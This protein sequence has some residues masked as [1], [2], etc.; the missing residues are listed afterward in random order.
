ML[1]RKMTVVVF[2]ILLAVL[3]IGVRQAIAMPSAQELVPDKPSKPDAGTPYIL[4][5]ATEIISATID[6]TQPIPSVSNSMSEDFEAT[7]P[8]PGWELDDT[9]TLDGGEF[10][11]NKR[12]CHPHTGGFAG[13]SVGGGAQGSALSC[14]ATYPDYSYTWALYGPFDLSSAFSASLDFHLWGRTEGYSGCPFD[15]FFVG[16]S[17]NAQQFYGTRYC[18][19]WTGGNA[20]NGYYSESLSLNDRL[21]QSQVWVGFL[22]KSDFSVV[23][24]G[25]TIDDVTLA[26]TGGQNPTNTPTPTPTT[27]T[28]PPPPGSRYTYLPIVGKQATATPTPT[29]TPTPTITPTPTS[30]PTSTPRPIG[31]WSGTTSQGN[32]MGFTANNDITNVSAFSI[33]FR[34]SCTYGSGSGTSYFLGTYPVNDNR[35]IISSGGATVTGTFTSSTTANGTWSKSWFDPY[36]GACTSNST[37]TAHP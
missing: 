7:W 17:I 26:V 27:T 6:L 32:N 1:T 13:W 14:S 25:I 23:Y 10:L 3:A 36:A 16:S 19:D 18:G 4:R 33:G 30:T 5:E 31:Q 34:F 37:W 12:D 22:L 8:A 29:S 2:C 35:F 21:G 11:W 28:S 15:Y 24:N 9:S 20:G